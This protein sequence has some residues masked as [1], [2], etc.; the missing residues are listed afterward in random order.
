MTFLVMFIFYLL[1]ASA[2]A[3]IADYLVPGRIPGG[4][5]ASA[6]VGVLGAWVGSNL[7]G[8]VGPQ[9]AGVPLL[10]AILGS[11]LLVF[12]FS[13]ISPRFVSAK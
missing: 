12:L 6:I 9:L 1:V 8:P 5:I 13:L 7:M 10:P 3:W 2:C 11:A 4:F